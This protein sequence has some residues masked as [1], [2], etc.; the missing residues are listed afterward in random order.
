MES[1]VC[2]ICYTEKKLKV[3]TKKSTQIDE[4]SL[5]KM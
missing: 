1:K 2:V 4:F 5:Q 3:S